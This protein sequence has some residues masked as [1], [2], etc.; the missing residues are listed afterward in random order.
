MKQL[1]QQLWGETAETDNLNFLNE[2][3]EEPFEDWLTNPKKHWEWHKRQYHRK[4]IYW[5][6]AS[7]TGKD[8]AFKALVYQHRITRHT[9]GTVQNKYVLKHLQ[10]LREEVELLR[11]RDKSG[12]AVKE[13][14][15]LLQKFERDIVE[16]EK[17]V[18]VLKGIADFEI[19]LDDG[20]GVNIE[21]F[22]KAVV[23]L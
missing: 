3:L 11:G 15:K 6:F 4:P 2:C 20:V 13:D 5:L 9:V 19:D 22:G 1:L 18:E 12:V 8:A 23:A 14:L 10:Y 7:S 16:C 17:Y 21:K